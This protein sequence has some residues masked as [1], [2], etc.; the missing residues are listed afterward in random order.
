MQNNRIL[1]ADDEPEIGEIISAVAEDIGFEATFVQEGDKVV[2][3]VATLDPSIIVLDLRMPGAD[4][5]EI[6]RELARSGCT[7]RIVLI[8]GMDQRTLNTVE[9]LGKDKNLDI[10]G[11]LTKPMYPEQIEDALKPYL[12]SESQAAPA[13]VPDS[14][15]WE[16]EYG[17]S[18]YFAPQQL[19]GVNGE[20]GGN[21]GNGKSG[22]NGE[23]GG[24]LRRVAL[25]IGWRLDGGGELRGD[26]LFQWAGE[27]Q[28]AKG[29]LT[30][31]LIEALQQWQQLGEGARKL[32]F[33]LPLASDMLKDNSLI[34]VIT[35]TTRRFGFPATN[36]VIETEEAG[37][38][39]SGSGAIEALSRL[40]I[41]G[42]KTAF[43]T[44]TDSEKLLTLIDKLPMDEIVV[45]M[46]FLKGKQGF[47]SN[48]E[49]EFSYSSLTSMARRKQVK[50]SARGVS[51]LHIAEF[52]RRCQFD[53]AEGPEIA[54]QTPISELARYGT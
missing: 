9:S 39:E 47:E 17:P 7:A 50:T 12:N 46:S 38:N 25:E 27:K 49:L 52:V 6:L 54:A 28:L 43:I 4:G 32:Q 21:G 34:K 33:V 5:V 22:G 19:L 24:E 31:L 8:S 53:W 10:I 48:M 16:K 13:P 36:L 2:A 3:R 14:T 26:E 15:V 42:F 51:T 30:L 41:A 37:I 23:S 44:E 40:R 35:E 20:N 18:V 1:I 29:L 11:T 45:D